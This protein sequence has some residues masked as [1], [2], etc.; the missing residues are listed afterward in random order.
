[1]TELETQIRQFN[2][3]AHEVNEVNE[4]FQEIT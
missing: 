3:E 1:M 2:H 4:V